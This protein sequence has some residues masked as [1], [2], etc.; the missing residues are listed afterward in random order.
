MYRLKNNEIRNDFLPEVL[1]VT[2]LRV[3]GSSGRTLTFPQSIWGTWNSTE[4]E[5]G[6]KIVRNVKL[7]SLED[8]AVNS[9]AV[10]YLMEVA[11]RK[12][13]EIKLLPL[14]RNNVSV[15]DVRYFAVTSC[16]ACA[17]PPLEQYTC[18]K[19]SWM[20]DYCQQD[21]EVNVV[22]SE[23]RMDAS[24]DPPC[25]GQSMM[26]INHTTWSNPDMHTHLSNGLQAEVSGLR[27]MQ[28]IVRDTWQKPPNAA[29]SSAGLSKKG[30]SLASVLSLHW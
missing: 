29:F 30:T 21:K 28:W 17:S 20:E 23:D 3:I 15:M 16:T 12:K 6:K 14:K 1:V 2:C 18:T 24:G 8:T 22:S 9:W 27:S 10:V 5:I 25:F 7:L 19:Q 13:N 11:S 26:L 4:S